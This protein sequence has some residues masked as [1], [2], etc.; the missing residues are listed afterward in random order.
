MAWYRV[1]FLGAPGDIRNV[2]EF[3]ANDDSS[4]L[5]LADGIHEAVSDLYAG[6]E[7]WQGSRRVFQCLH[8]TARPFIP[9]HVVTEKLQSQM[10]KREEIL[11]ESRTAFARSRHL[12][13]RI[14]ELQD[15]F[16]QPRRR[17]ALQPSRKSDP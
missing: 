11:Y 16:G 1:Y 17:K 2:D 12:I 4:A 10:L 6:Y 15:L 9:E 13:E 5:T 7:V 8:E 14:N 3:V